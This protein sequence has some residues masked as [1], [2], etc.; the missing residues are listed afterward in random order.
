MDDEGLLR[1][2][3]RSM[4]AAQDIIDGL[5]KTLENAMDM[6]LERDRESECAKQI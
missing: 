3:M 2:V 4:S 6:E 1:S 5:V